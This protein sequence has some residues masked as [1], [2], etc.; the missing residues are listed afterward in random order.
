LEAE[1]KSAGGRLEGYPELSL[2]KAFP[3]GATT[4][5]GTG[6]PVNLGAKH[7]MVEFAVENIGP[8]WKLHG[9]QALPSHRRQ[10]ICADAEGSKADRL[11][12]YNIHLQNLADQIPVPLTVCG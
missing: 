11:R 6:R 1:R 9:A 12:A 5:H 8:W 2:T 7:A 10:L 3:M 4:A